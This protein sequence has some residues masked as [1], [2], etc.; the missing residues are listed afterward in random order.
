MHPG[1]YSRLLKNDSILGV[2]NEFL[3]KLQQLQE[4]FV[5]KILY[6]VKILFSLVKRGMLPFLKN[7]IFDGNAYDQR[8]KLIGQE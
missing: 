6:V 5:S 8:F 2:E 4:N 3:S 7:C 1:I